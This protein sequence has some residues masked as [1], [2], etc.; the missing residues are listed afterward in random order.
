MNKK[1][2]VV[3]AG[4]SGL[5]TV[6][7]LLEEGHEVVCYE[8]NSDIGGVFSERN[9]YDSVELTVSNYYMAYSDFMPFD[10]D[11]K[12][13]TRREYKE[14]LDRYAK[15]FGLLE[16]INFNSKL[17]NIKKQSGCYQLTFQDNKG[18]VTTES[19]EHVC[20]CS[21]QF[22][23]PNIPDICG[24]D[25][26]GGISMHSSEYINAAKCENLKGKRILFLGMGESS[27]DIVT[28]LAEIAGRALLSIRKP[29]SFSSKT[30]GDN[31]PIDMFQTRY[32]H[33]LPAKTKANKVRNIWK[34][35]LANP[36]CTG[37]KAI[38]AKHMIEGPDEPGSVVTKTGRI[39]EAAAKNLEIDVGGIERIDGDTVTFCSGRTEQFDAIV[40]CTG[41]KIHL[42]F[43]NEDEHFHDIRDC[44]LQMFSP[45]VRTRLVFIGFARPQQGGV[46]AIAELQ[47]RYYAK[48]L[49]GTLSLPD[50]TSELA[51]QDKLR[52]QREFYESPNVVG[53]VNGLRFNE[54]IAELLGCRIQPPSLLFSPRQFFVYWFHHVWPCQYRVVGP[55]ATPLAREMWLS[56]PSV[57]SFKQKAML[58]LS[59]AVKRIKHSRFR[60]DKH[61]WRPAFSKK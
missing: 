52:W 48:V 33:S 27:A 36:S 57:Y 14:Y 18:N 3:G 42:P 38:M 49:S 56:A 61:Q 6:K 23:K 15:N 8:Q 2:V 54:R 55:G 46:P 50:N 9:T 10:E 11:I 1:V 25:S 16:K 34:K 4:L 19:C 40:F 47:A 21:G 13:W 41:F 22:Q 31:K 5:V 37:A 35:V 24:L 29:H 45:I 28:E 39:F 53:L 30:V 20:I 17:L 60:D 51:L 32:W 43:L 58:V 44:Y 26:F 12:F 59:I 7:E